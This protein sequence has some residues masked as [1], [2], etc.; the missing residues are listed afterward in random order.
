[1][2]RKVFFSFHYQNDIWRVNQIRHSNMIEGS[3]AAGWSDA[4]LWEE[5]KRKGDAAIKALINEGLRETTV[6]AVLIGTHTTER[7][8]VQYEID[9]SIER[10]NGLFGI[11]IHNVEDRYGYTCPEGANPFDRLRLTSSN[12]LLSSLYRSYDWVLGDGYHNLGNWAE[13]AAVRAGK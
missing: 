7:Q 5:A 9:K 3:A 11:Y 1:M 6:T 10:G 4:S 8:Y 2:S 13:Y 12:Q